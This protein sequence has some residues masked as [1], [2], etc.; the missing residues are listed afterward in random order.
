MQNAYTGSITETATPDIL[1]KCHL[2]LKN[3]KKVNEQAVRATSLTEIQACLTAGMCN[4]EKEF[5]RPMTV[6]IFC[7][8]QTSTSLGY[9]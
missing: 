9:S 1:W 7:F 5:G 2:L 4:F 3:E 8:S 6:I